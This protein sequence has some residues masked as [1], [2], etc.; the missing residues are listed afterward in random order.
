[1]P[2]SQSTISCC[3]ICGS[4]A[5]YNGSILLSTE[6]SQ[7]SSVIV[8]DTTIKASTGPPMLA[9]IYISGRTTYPNGSII[10]AVAKGG[11]VRPHGYLLEVSNI[12]SL[13][14]NPPLYRDIIRRSRIS[15]T[16]AVVSVARVRDEDVYFEL[17]VVSPV[18][19]IYDAPDWVVT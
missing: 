12:I 19:D 18:G 6:S 13:L 7:F 4:F 9:K 1:M 3:V 15:A 16:G 8:Y 10:C 11:P 2:L 14:S 5:L 17:E